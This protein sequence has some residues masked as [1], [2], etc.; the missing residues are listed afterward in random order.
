MEWALRLASLLGFILFVGCGKTPN[1]ASP[2]AEPTPAAKVIQLPGGTEWL[3]PCGE[4][5]VAIRRVM[6][7][8]PRPEEVYVWDWND[9]EKPPLIGKGQS[10]KV[11][12]ECVE[13][14]LAPNSIITQPDTLMAFHLDQPTDPTRPIFIKD[15]GSGSLIK[16]LELGHTW[17]CREIRTSSNG[18]F[19]VIQALPDDDSYAGKRS[20]VRVGIISSESKEIAWAPVIRDTQGTL[21]MT[22]SIPSEDGRFVATVGVNNGS[23]ICLV[24]VGQ[25]NVMWE[26]VDKMS[27]GFRDAVFSPDSKQVYAGGGGGVYETTLDPPESG[28][29]RIVVEAR[30]DGKRLGIEETTFD[31]GRPNQEFERLAID[32]PLLKKIAQAT[33]GEYYEPANF[34][35]L[36]ERLRSRVIKEDIHREFGV[37]TVGGLFGVLFGVFLALISGEWLLRKFYQLN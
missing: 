5:L 13:A 22:K 7:D 14:F 31:V 28:S 33:G 32:R 16:R 18:K 3:Y 36:V 26:F 24:E 35:D 12:V 21:C 17:F 29:Y 8:P 11:R 4:R 6:G 1:P 37:Q 25:M 34:G 20:D 23:W 19:A 2:A 27:V 15:F 10:G 9:L 30:K